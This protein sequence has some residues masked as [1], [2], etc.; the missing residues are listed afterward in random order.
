MYA[1]RSVIRGA[2][3]GAA[4]TTALN[5][6]TYL[7]MVIRARPASS[8]P[9][10]SV[11][12]LST[13]VGVE[14][15]GKDEE[16]QNRVEGLAPMLGIATGVGTGV[17]LGAVRATGWRPG[18]LVTATA[19]TLVAVVGANAPMTALGISDP[20]SWSISDWVSDVVP[21]VVFG[22]VTASVLHGLDTK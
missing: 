16:R 9:Q 4:A 11:E 19:A 5:T 2:A 13:T 17:L 7:D 15:P 8:T 10:E 3:A 1:L 6:V 14:I 21:H 20:R 12:K 22:A 18:P